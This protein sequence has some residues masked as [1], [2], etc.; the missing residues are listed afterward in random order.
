MPLNQWIATRRDFLK[1]TGLL[2]AGL[3][4][5][6]ALTGAKSVKCRFGLVT[7]PH[8]ADIDTL[9]SRSYRESIRKMDECVALMNEAKVDLL[10]ELGDLTNGTPEGTTRHLER[11]EAVFRKFDGPRYHVIGN[12]DLDSLSK[13]QYQ[14]VVDNTAI[15]E[16]STYYSFNRNGIHFVVLDANFRADG[17]PYDSGNFHWTDSNIPEAQLN[18]LKADLEGMEMPVIICIH[19]LLDSGEER[20]GGEY[21]GNGSQVRRILESNPG[22]MAV[23]QGH[24]HRGQYHLV[25]DIHYYTLKAMVEGSGPDN[26]SYAIVEVFDDLSMAITG[27]RRADSLSEIIT[28]G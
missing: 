27:Y 18:W 7:D 12:H 19:Q 24:Q 2:A 15:P 23:F 26:S 13:E 17:T 4:L 6:P 25:H 22:V 8:F 21:I 10:I 3:C 11:I 14:S 5:N 1:K 28:R 9:G 16:G 20:E